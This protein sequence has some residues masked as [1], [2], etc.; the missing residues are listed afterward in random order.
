MDLATLL[1][2]LTAAQAALAQNDLA[3]LQAFQASALNGATFTVAGFTEAIT[4]VP[5]QL[6]DP[7]RQNRMAVIA[8]ALEI[9]LAQF[10]SLLAD[11][12][13]AAAAGA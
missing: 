10:G 9:A 11:T 6:G 3:V 1:S 13:S 4:A 12:A 2:N 5:A 7:D 8:S